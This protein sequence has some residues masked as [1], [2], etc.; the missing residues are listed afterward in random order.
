MNIQ[1]IGKKEWWQEFRKGDAFFIL[2]ISQLS[3]AEKISYTGEEE[4]INKSYSCQKPL[5]RHSQEEF[6]T[7]K[8]N[9]ENSR[10]ALR[11]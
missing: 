10:V 8:S 1:F 5:S 6:C 4:I 11:K 2:E 9:R 7:L 3:T